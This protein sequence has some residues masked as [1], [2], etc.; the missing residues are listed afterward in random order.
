MRKFTN[1]LHSFIEKITG[2]S[3]YVKLGIYKTK[4]IKY[5]PKF[6][7]SYLALIADYIDRI[8]TFKPSNIFEIGANYGQDAEFLRKR[9]G[10]ENS[11]VYI[12]EPHPEI[13]AEAERYFSFNCYP[14][15]ISDKNEKITFHAIKLES[16]NTGIS[17]LKK[18]KF[19]KED[20]YFDVEVETIRMD[21]FFEINNIDEIDFLKIDVEG[22]AYEVLNGF[23]N[24][25]KRVKAIQLESE[26][27]PIWVGQ[28]TWTHISNMLLDNDF[29]LIHFELQ[30]DGIQSDSFWIQKKFVNHQIYDI[31]TQKWHQ[32]NI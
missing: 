8:A 18:H 24:E 10:L 21:D 3:I 31:S 6:S 7:A 29:Q 14:L 1:N 9:F 27:I 28:K 25:L 22:A 19:N 23:G 15:A 4:K 16:S 13:I 30:E 11:D 26:Y 12:F 17:S 5:A 20:D 2:T 32:E